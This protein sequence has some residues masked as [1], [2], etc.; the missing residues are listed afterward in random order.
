MRLQAALAKQAWHDEQA[1]L[2]FAYAL[3]AMTK[4]AASKAMNG[5]CLETTSLQHCYGITC[6]DVYPTEAASSLSQA[7]LA[8]K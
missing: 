3:Q 7:S 5:L 1:H 8:T 2:T 4:E 6:L